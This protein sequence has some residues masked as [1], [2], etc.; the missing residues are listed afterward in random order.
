MA[1]RKRSKSALIR[2]A[3]EE[4]GPEARNRDVIEH[5]AARRVKVS[6]QMVSVVR[7]RAAEETASRRGP[8]RPRQAVFSL[9]ALLQA[10]RLVAEAG[11]LEAARRTRGALAQLS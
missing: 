9:S 8:G 1:P 10:K 7:A 11:S 3:L 4:L 2:R 5:L 6:A